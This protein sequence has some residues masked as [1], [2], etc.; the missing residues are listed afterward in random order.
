MIFAKT[1]FALAV[2]SIASLA[3]AGDIKPFNQQ[4]FDQLTKGGKPVVLD[5]SA[6]WCPTCKAQKPI[7][8]GLMKQ[9]A[10]KDVTLMTIDFDSAKPTLKAFKVGSQSTIIAFKGDKEVGRSVGDTT[11]AGLEGLVKKTVN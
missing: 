4:E 5:V 3:L 8:D 7:I 6:P 9:P 11:P 2:T 1:V 10:Y